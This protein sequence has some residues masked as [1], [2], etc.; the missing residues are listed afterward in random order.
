[1][2]WKENKA[3]WMKPLRLSSVRVMGGLIFCSPR[4]L[5]KQKKTIHFTFLYKPSLERIIC[6]LV[7]FV[8]FCC[9]GTSGEERSRKTYVNFRTRLCKDKWLRL[10]D[11]C[12][13]SSLQSLFVLKVKEYRRLENEK[14]NR[15]GGGGGVG[16]RPSNEAI[17]DTTF[18]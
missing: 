11:S 17:V 10:M 3:E 14:M 12:R 15:S 9:T 16:G 8:S 2:S 7:F 5:K 18:L 13:G 4:R 6:A 1:M